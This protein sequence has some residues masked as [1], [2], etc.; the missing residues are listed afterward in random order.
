M[1]EQ[2][3]SID[4][5]MGKFPGVLDA[6]GVK[7]D[8]AVFGK[9]TDNAKLLYGQVVDK[10]QSDI[11]AVG[12]PS[13]SSAVEKAIEETTQ[14]I[15][16]ANRINIKSIVSGS[17][18]PTDLFPEDI[19]KP[20][21]DYIDDFFVRNDGD[22]GGKHREFTTGI[23]SVIESLDDTKVSEWAKGE[24]AHWKRDLADGA[25]F[26]EKRGGIVSKLINNVV[27]NSINLSNNVILGNP[28]EL[29]IK[30]PT[31]YG[32]RPSLV[33]LIEAL[34]KTKGN[35][36]GKIPE[37][38][39]RGFYGFDLGPSKNFGV[40]KIRIP[41]TGKLND[42][43]KG[44]TGLIMNITQRPLVNIAYGV[45]R[46]KTGTVNGGIEA[47]EKI[48]FANRLGNRPRLFRN[49]ADAASLK[50]MNYTLSQYQMMNSL[51]R[52][53]GTPGKR[54]DS[55]RGIVTW[56]GITSAL[57]GSAAMIPAPISAIFKK[58]DGYSDWEKEHSTAFT[59]LIQPGSISIG[60]GQQIYSRAMESS[61]KDI[62]SGAQ[63]LS[64]GDMNGAIRDLTMGGLTVSIGFGQ[65]VM[66]NPRTQKSIR[67]YF[68][69][70]DGDLSESEKDEKL[71]KIWLPFLNQD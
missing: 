9:L 22:I 58:I 17:M 64:E 20:I 15:T 59:K 37:L 60:A 54:F 68:D 53:L 55:A 52:G 4:N 7:T 44:T 11:L 16:E 34:G 23:K 56:L 51:V 18:K 24:W 57:G 39:Q 66:T 49:S 69:L 32:F 25:P 35:I 67:V 27:S 63:K 2:S 26:Y 3:C 41:L 29:M 43:V 28:L 62:Q 40:G 21:L 5:V 1:P 47:L 42:L 12:N 31:L 65:N 10:Q 45:G 8:D 48:A 33:G 36:W 14:N 71:Q 19:T 50:L 46:A 61:Q 38:D 70:A 6:G 13:V 30:A